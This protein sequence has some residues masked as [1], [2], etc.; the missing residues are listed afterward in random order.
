MFG[1]ELREQRANDVRARR[2]QTLKCRV[3]PSARPITGGPSIITWSNFSLAIDTRLT[4][5]GPIS[6]SAGFGGSGPVGMYIRP[7]VSVAWMTSV[8]FEAPAR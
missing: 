7:G 6:S 8:A 5:F 2:V 4:I 1:A 3:S